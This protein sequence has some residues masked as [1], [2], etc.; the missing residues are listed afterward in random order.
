MSGVWKNHTHALCI[1]EAPYM[2]ANV[3]ILPLKTQECAYNTAENARMCPYY[4]LKT[5]ECAYNTV[6]NTRMCL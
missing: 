2:G 4:G 3:P 1:I 6:E 5:Q